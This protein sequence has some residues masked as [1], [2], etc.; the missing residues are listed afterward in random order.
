M[1]TRLLNT[2]RAIAKPITDRKFPAPRVLTLQNLAKP[3]SLMGVGAL[4]TAY[5]VENPHIYF[6]S[7]GLGPEGDV[8]VRIVMAAVGA[9]AV[10]SEKK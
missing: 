5:S 10:F 9:Y 4:A 8:V 3:S 2:L 1:K 6:E 7:L